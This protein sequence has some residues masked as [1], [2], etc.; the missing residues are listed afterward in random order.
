MIMRFKR[1]WCMLGCS[2][3]CGRWLSG[4]KERKKEGKK[5]EVERREHHQRVFELFQNTNLPIG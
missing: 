3:C 5:R 2:I 1:C 4:E